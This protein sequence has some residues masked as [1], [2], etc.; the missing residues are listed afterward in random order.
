MI[1]KRGDKVL[2]RDEF[3][4]WH[5]DQFTYGI[6]PYECYRGNIVQIINVGTTRDVIS[7][8][9]ILCITFTDDLLQGTK[10]VHIHPSKGTFSGDGYGP[11]VF[12]LAGSGIR[13]SIQDSK[14][15]AQVSINHWNCK[16]NKCGRDAY[17]GFNQVECS[18]PG[19][20]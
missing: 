13:W 17:Q 8:W 15:P 9:D 16:C 20:R 1:P 7:G 11:V 10:R 18:N 4:D 6:N 14:K 3:L 2:F 12:Q 19:C 5:K